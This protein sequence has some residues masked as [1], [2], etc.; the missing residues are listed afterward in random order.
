MRVGTRSEHN[1][2]GGTKISVQGGPVTTLLI[3]VERIRS[4]N[5]EIYQGST[6]ATPLYFCRHAFVFYS[7]CN[8]SYRLFR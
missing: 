2:A 3:F 7:V 4:E 8:V 1:F 6:Q 5:G